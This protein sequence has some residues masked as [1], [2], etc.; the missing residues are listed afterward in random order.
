MI[1]LL[2]V[3]C[4]PTIDNELPL[5]NNTKFTLYAGEA[6]SAVT[7]KIADAYAAY[8]I[9][10]GIQVPLFKFVKHRNYEI[11]IGIPYNCSILQLIKNQTE[12]R[13]CSQLYIRK[14]SLCFFN[15]YS[16]D[17]IWIT[18]SAS[19]TADKSLFYIL[20]IARSQK[21]SNS[22]FTQTALSGRIKK[23]LK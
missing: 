13:D 14:D 17:G 11:F 21:L 8:F 20:T 5:F 16:K 4:S 9:G 22:L 6:V 1:V 3:A 12:T 18:E 7:P 19:I 15:K 23:N 2:F 10:E